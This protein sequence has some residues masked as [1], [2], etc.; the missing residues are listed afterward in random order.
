MASVLNK[1][2]TKEQGGKL[3]YCLTYLAPQDVITI[4]LDGEGLVK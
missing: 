1:G 4:E 3:E 2:G